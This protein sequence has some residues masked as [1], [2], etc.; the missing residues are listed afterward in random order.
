MIDW[1]LKSEEEQIAFVSK[2]GYAI[3]YIDNP[4]EVVQTAA[5]NQNGYVLHHIKNPSEA[6]RL[7]AVRQYGGAI[8]YINNPTKQ[9]I[10]IALTDQKFI[11][12]RAT[13]EQIIKRI[14]A[15]NALMMRKWIRYGK[16]M[17][18]S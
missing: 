15:N 13:Y 3:V 5:V 11:V 7:A 8:Y 16:N 18:N 17:R 10:K 4:S 9:E 6:V 1:N 2:D 12:F 14:F